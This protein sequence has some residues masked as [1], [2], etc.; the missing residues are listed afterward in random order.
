[1]KTILLISAFLACSLAGAQNSRKPSLQFI[2][3]EEGKLSAVPAFHEPGEIYIPETS[4]KTYKPSDVRMEKLSMEQ[5]SFPSEYLPVLMER[6]MDMNVLSEAYK[7][8]FNIYTPMLRRV[9]PMA[10][11]FDEY[12]IYPVGVNGA[13]MVNGRQFSWPAIGG[14][15][16]AEAAIAWTNERLTVSGGLFAGR[17][18]SPYVSSPGFIGGININTRYEVND[19][20]ALRGWGQYSYSDKNGKDPFLQMNPLLNQT[21]LGGAVEFKVG[22]NAG[23]GIGVNFQRNNFNNRME[24]QYI[25]YPDFGGGNDK[26]KFGISGG[27]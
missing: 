3:N 19:W 4:Y 16:T 21:N 20:L 24:R 9:S 26:I 22:D 8:F 23:F 14:T 11:D 5:K 18:Y 7:P 15:T 10:L 17:Y 27:R 2:V 6:P 25:F 13:F 1:M 12:A